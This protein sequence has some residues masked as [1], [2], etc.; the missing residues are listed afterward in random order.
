MGR[1]SWNIATWW[2]LTGWIVDVDWCWLEV[3]VGSEFSFE[4][5]WF[6]W[7]GCSR[8]QHNPNIKSSWY[9]S[10]FRLR[11]LDSTVSFLLSE[12][13]SKNMAWLKWDANKPNLLAYQSY[14]Q[15]NQNLHHR[16][17][18]HLH[19]QHGASNINGPPPWILRLDSHQAS[20]MQRWDPKL[21]D[22][23]RAPPV[24]M[25]KGPIETSRELHENGAAFVCIYNHHS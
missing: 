21:K 9:Q 20:L 8:R 14:P 18:W 5:S 2:W 7:I 13:F 17:G 11:F 3:D 23:P 25:W 16:G 24:R 4:Y 1:M 12:H 10:L 19:G 22:G 6:G 15:A